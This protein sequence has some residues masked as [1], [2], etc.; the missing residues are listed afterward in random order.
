MRQR[1]LTLQI[2]QF[3][4]PPHFSRHLLNNSMKLDTKKQLKQ[5]IM[6]RVV[7]SVGLT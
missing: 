3:N 6:C 2:L 5:I 7:T 4:I 1:M